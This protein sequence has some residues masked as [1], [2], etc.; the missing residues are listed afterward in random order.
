MITVIKHSAKNSEAARVHADS[1]RNSA[2]GQAKGA[3]LLSADTER[4]EPKHLLEKIIAGDVFVEGTPAKEVNWKEDAV[5]V[6]VDGAEKQLADLE[7]VCPGFLA[8]FGPKSE[9]SLG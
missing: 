1:I 2:V 6:A 4:A 9:L 7:K 3:L 5:I 8:A